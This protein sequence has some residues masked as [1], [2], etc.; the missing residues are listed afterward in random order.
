MLIPSRVSQVNSY[1]HLPPNRRGVFSC[2][3]DPTQKRRTRGLSKF[4]RTDLTSAAEATIAAGLSV[5]G[6]EVDPVSGKIRVL[7]GDAAKAKA[8][9]SIIG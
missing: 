9:N 1:F 4:K 6:V 5:R 7:V 2:V 3:V 8:T